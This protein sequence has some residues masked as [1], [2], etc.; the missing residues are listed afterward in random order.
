MQT[1]RRSLFFVAVLVLLAACAAPP[2]IDDARAAYCDA[3]GAYGQA[4]LQLR[5]ITETST[6]DEY[7]AAL[8]DVENAWNELQS[9]SAALADVQSD[10]LRQA[11]QE[12][13]GTID[14]IAGDATIGEARTTIRTATLNTLAAY[15]EIMTTVCDY[16]QP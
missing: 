5:D 13:A 6:V 15:N 4:V 2:T 9:A 10:A 11:N 8:S 7:R 3:L 12:L 1:F 16:D 14:A